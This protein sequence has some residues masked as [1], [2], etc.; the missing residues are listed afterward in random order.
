MAADGR[1]TRMRHSTSRQIPVL[2]FDAH[3]LVAVIARLRACNALG[4]ALAV[5]AVGYGLDTTLPL[6]P[7]AAGIAVLALTSPALLWRLRG[8]WPVG[9]LEA[10]GHLAIDIALLG[11]ALYFTGGASN[12]FITLLLVPVALAAAALS[13]RATAAVTACAAAVYLL[14]VFRYVPLPDMPAQGGGFRL[15]LTGMTVNFMIAIVLLAVFVGRTR[16]SLAAQRE[17]TRRLRERALRDEAILAI[18]TQAADAAHRLNTP[19]STLRTLVSEL[20]RGRA[21]DRELGGDLAVMGDE[22]ERC[23]HIL[24]DMVDYGRR[25]LEGG[26]RTTTVADYVAT[27]ADR[28]RLLQPEAELAVSVSPAAGPCAIAVQPALAHALLNHMQNALDASRRQA[29]QAV[30]LDARLARGQ[31]E[32]T[33]GDRGDG[34][35][36]DLAANPPL[37]SDK[38]DGLGIGLALAHATIER[39]RGEVRTYSGT[40]GTRVCVYLPLARGTT[41]DA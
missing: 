8:P 23:R 15:H 38:P 16:A 13:G 32:L 27:N 3:A 18:A 28:F 24:R 20:A 31:L 26:A 39:L 6:A 34:F 29:S 35:R 36:A 21:D 40:E 4:Q 17:A 37:A 11:W 19:L 41:P 10:A 22:V 25:Q 12:P 30:T 9:E 2:P 7:L 5:A 1:A 14:L 33:I